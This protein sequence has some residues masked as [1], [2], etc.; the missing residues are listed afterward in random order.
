MLY[1]DILHLFSKISVLRS[2]TTNTVVFLS[3][4]NSL[5]LKKEGNG[6]SLV[7]KC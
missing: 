1:T 5:Y 3:N 6:N 4:F 7:G 2:E